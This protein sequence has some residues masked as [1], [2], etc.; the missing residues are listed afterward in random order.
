MSK[1][2]WV[3]RKSVLPGP[4]LL[5][6]WLEVA[7]SMWC[8]SRGLGGAPVSGGG[9]GVVRLEGGAPNLVCELTGGAPRVN[10]GN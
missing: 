1:K 8:V 4:L 5:L 3:G 2:V 7:S 9:G 10:G 6:K